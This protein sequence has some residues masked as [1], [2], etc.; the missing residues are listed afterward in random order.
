MVSNLP[1]GYNDDYGDD[2]V[3]YV[4]EESYLELQ[5]AHNEALNLLEQ[6][7]LALPQTEVEV[8]QEISAWMEANLPRLNEHE[9]WQNALARWRGERV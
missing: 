3:G 9:P 2:P 6:A 5:Q 8:R 1:P 7:W 4:D